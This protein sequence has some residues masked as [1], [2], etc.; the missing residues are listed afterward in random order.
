MHNRENALNKWLEKI[1]TP[2]QFSIHPLTGDAS[3][4]RYYRLQDKQTN[5]IVMDAPPQ[6]ETIEPFIRVAGQL[7]QAGIRTPTIHAFD[8]AQGFAILEDFGDQL[9]LSQLGSD[10]AESLYL[11]A[12]D[13]LNL[14]Q[15]CSTSALP[16]FNKQFILQELTIF[17]EWFLQAYLKIELTT[18]EEELLDNS[19][20]WLSNEILQQPTV[21]IHRDYHSRNIMVI[22]NKNNIELG[23]IDFQ[24]AMLGPIT[25]DLVSLLKDCYI[26]WPREKIESRLSY[27]YN[28][29]EHVK[30]HYSLPAF[31]KAFDYCGLQ[32][33]L[34]VLGVFSRLHL[35]DNKSNYLNDLPLTLNY[36]SA[37]L[38][39]SNELED[40]RQFIQNRIRL[41]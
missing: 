38:E 35:R 12:I 7:S 32:R 13:T 3:F 24:D 8:I 26:Q 29:S 5:Q 34:K 21:F 41:P 20:D 22:P 27:F 36:V 33:H 11:S 19:F 17:K 28:Q 10:D 15:K 25:Y 6:K 16:C 14:M 23:I 39:V 1:L 40:F 30:Q 9:L 2:P 31:I 37:T 4:R 18:Q